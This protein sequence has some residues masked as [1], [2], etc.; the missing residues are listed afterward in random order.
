MSAPSP[1]GTEERIS[2]T[3][4]LA[5][6][7]PQ[8]GSPSHQLEVQSTLVQRGFQQGSEGQRLGIRRQEKGKKGATN[9]WWKQAKI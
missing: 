4:P 3:H 8:E 1:S 6:V 9:D 7:V 2:L 5:K